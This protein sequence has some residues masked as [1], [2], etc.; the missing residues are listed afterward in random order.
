[1]LLGNKVIGP[2]LLRKGL[3]EQSLDCQSDWIGVTL[4]SAYFIVLSLIPKLRASRNGCAAYALMMP[5]IILGG[6]YGAVFTP[7]EAFAVA[8]AYAL[9]VGGVVYREIGC[10]DLLPIFKKSA[11]SSSVIVFT[12]ANAGLFAYL[13]ARAGVPNA[14]GVFLKVWLQSPMLFLLGVNVALFP[15]GMF[16]ET[17]AAIIVLAPILAPVAVHFG[18]D[19]IHFGIVMAVNLALGMITPLFGVNLFAACT[20]AKISLDRIVMQFVPFVGVVLTRLMII[21][22][23]TGISLFLRDSVYAK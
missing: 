3:S 18:I 1:M 19:P 17:S 10:K 16:I 6:I 4:F 14:I 21:T 7:T 9:F 13:I 23:V 22:Y 8:V 2:A 15:I 5:V 20:V 12:T 11:L